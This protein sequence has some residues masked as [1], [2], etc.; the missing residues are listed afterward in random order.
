MALTFKQLVLLLAACLL[1][2]CADRYQPREIVLSREVES[3]P[4]T[5]HDG[6]FLIHVAVNDAQPQ[7]FLLD[8]GMGVTTVFK[9]LADTLR[10]STEKL[11]MTQG[12]PLGEFATAT[13]SFAHVQRMR[14]GAAEFRD[15]M[16]EVKDAK[17][18]GHPAYAGIL[19]FSAFGDTVW[20]FDGPGRRIL[21]GRDKALPA[22]DAIPLRIFG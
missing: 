1:P 2:A 10:L 3:I 13:S 9:D 6:A 8:T 12:S 11:P 5:E 15:V 17:D 21:L 20:T 18:L 4:L 16:V 7:P 14:I 22:A 19:G